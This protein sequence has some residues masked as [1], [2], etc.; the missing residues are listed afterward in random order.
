MSRKPVIAYVSSSDPFN[1]RVW[2]GTHY[3]IYK[4]LTQLGTVKIC[5]PF[6]PRFRLFLGAII[7]QL[8]LKLTG[9]RF[10]YRH[11]FLVAK[12]YGAYFKKQINAIRPDIIIAP[13]ASA[14]IAFLDTDIPIIYMTDG[15][16]E[17]CLNY[18]KALTNLIQFNITE[19]HSIERRAITKSH[20]IIV[21]SDWAAQS[22]IH[23]YHKPAHQVICLPYG[24]NFE[25]L[26]HKV[27]FHLPNKPFRLLFVGVYWESKGGDIAFKAFELLKKKGI[28]VSFTI[29]GCNP[30]ERYKNDQ[31]TIIPFLDKNS[32]EGQEKMKEVYSTHHLL[33][34]PTRF[35]CT[36]IVINEASAFGIPSLVANSGGV[37]GHLIEGKNG[38]LLPYD[39]QG[40]GYA[41]LIESLIDDP[42]K[43]ADLRLS[44]RK[45]YE[46]EL[47]WDHWRISVQ[48][49]INELIS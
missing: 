13:A 15:T 11:S 24:A 8:L 43:Y 45:I 44:S 36:P 35:D 40:D 32:E 1:K 16:F 10:D 27:D 33:L 17:S 28:D 37:S 20:R 5:G 7:N 23:H 42:N 2:S 12:A 25:S 19:G 39:D 26:P 47:N 22:V 9:K 29:M 6:E 31:V 21:S 3:S 46:E 38:F 4:S 48:N 30:P 49:V 14:E 41:K 34:L 18:H